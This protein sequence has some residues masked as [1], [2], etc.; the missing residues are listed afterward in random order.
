MTRSPVDGTVHDSRGEQQSDFLIRSVD[1]VGTTCNVIRTGRCRQVLSLWTG[2]WAD[3][4]LNREQFRQ[5]YV[6]GHYLFS[7]VQ[8][9]LCE[10]GSLRGNKL[11]EVKPQVT[12]TPAMEKL[13]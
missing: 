2:G 4:R 3:E 13:C 8:Q 1:A 9:N 11:S 7:H 5:R 10:Y 6:S 12:R